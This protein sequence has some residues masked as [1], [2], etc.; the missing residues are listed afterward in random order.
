[1]QVLFRVASRR[2]G[3]AR[4]RASGSPVIY[5]VSVV[6]GCPVWMWSWQAVQ[7]TR[8]CVAVAP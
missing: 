8:A 1:M 5:A 4:F 7:T 6:A 2:T 3:Q